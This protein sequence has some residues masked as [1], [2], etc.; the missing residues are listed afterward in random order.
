MIRTLQLFTLL[1]SFILLSCSLEQQRKPNVIFILADQW[2]ASDLGYAGNSEVKTPMLD[3]FAKKAINFKNA[4]T[5]TPVCT[6]YRAA[7][8]TGKYPSTTGMFLNDIYLPA[9]EV[10][11]PEIYK[12]AG[13]QT[14]YIGKWHLD[15]HGREIFIE[16][17]R[18]QG[19]DF[20]KASECDHNHQNEHYYLNNDTTKRFWSG[21]SPNAVSE[22]A[23]QYL[24]SASMRQDPFLLFLS[25]T[26]PHFPHGTA[27]KEFYEMYSRTQLTLP[28]NVSDEMYDWALKELYGYYAHCTATDRAIGS[29]IQKIKD[30]G[31]YENSIIIFTSDHGEMLGSHGF[32]PYMKHQPYLE[33]I[34]VPFI[35]SYPNMSV[36]G[37]KVA[38]APLSTPDI[39]PSLLSLSGIEI[40]QEIQGCDLSQIMKDP[41][42]SKDRSALIMNLCPFDIA[43]QDEEYRAIKTNEYTYVKT[44]RGPSL[45]FHDKKDPYQLENLIGNPKYAVIQREL[46][47]KLI[48]DLSKIGETK[49]EPRNYYLKKFGYEGQNGINKKYVIKNYFNIKEPISPVLAE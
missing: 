5:V 12:E 11:M 34:N 6:P 10:T 17:E 26:S 27:P 30:L 15:G 49:I 37:G 29:I 23:Q 42:K 38:I 45:L 35:I 31:I 33:S 24:E 9:K 47:Q 44:P 21:Y 7:L 46:D 28:P 3:D 20:W 40:P 18:R 16:P 39:L 13:Y 36:E 14:A 19:F 48:N 43:F 1:F 4:V 22:S 8:L 2:R 41:E 32:R 25:F